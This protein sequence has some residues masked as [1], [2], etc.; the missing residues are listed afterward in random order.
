MV[1]HVRIRPAPKMRACRRVEAARQICNKGR[2]QEHR[3]AGGRASA[4]FLFQ[5]PPETSAMSCPWESS[6]APRARPLAASLVNLKL[7]HQLLPTLKVRHCL[8]G[9]QNSPPTIT[10]IEAPTPD[11]LR[12]N[13]DDSSALEERSAPSD[14]LWFAAALAN[15]AKR[16][17]NVPNMVGQVNPSCHRAPPFPPLCRVLKPEERCRSRSGLPVPFGKRLH[18]VKDVPLATISSCAMKR[19]QCRTGAQSY[20]NL[21]GSSQSAPQSWSEFGQA[22]QVSHWSFLQS[23]PRLRS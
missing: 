10:P 21:R 20:R 6:A 8:S 13:I 12:K 22:F 3:S 4:P 18:R 7:R 16:L 17:D 5:R 9:P 1:T 23:L 15:S 19:G 2:K 14:A 11:E